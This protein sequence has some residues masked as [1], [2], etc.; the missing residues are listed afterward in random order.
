MRRRP[1]RGVAGRFDKRPTTPRS[2]RVYG[3]DVVTCGVP[4]LCV[5]H[6]PAPQAFLP[7]TRY[8]Y[9][10]PDRGTVP[11][12]NAVAP[13]ARLLQTSSPPPGPTGRLETKPRMA[14]WL[15]AERAASK[16]QMTLSKARIFPTSW[17]RAAGCPVQAMAGKSSTIVM[18][19]MFCPVPDV[20]LSVA[21][22]HRRRTDWPAPA[23]GRFTVVWK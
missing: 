17:G 16:V 23:A 20:E 6:G 15:V 22:L 1:S 19:S 8:Q 11:S 4:L 12:E 3:H 2:T 5:P 7:F 14:T 21:T 13:G 10:D 18:L 9:D